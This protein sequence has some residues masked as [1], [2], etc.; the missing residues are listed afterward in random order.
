[1]RAW[2]T[3]VAIVALLATILITQVS[4]EKSDAVEGLAAYDAY[5]DDISSVS[6]DGIQ[7]HDDILTDQYLQSDLN[8][9]IGKEAAGAGD[10]QHSVAVQGYYNTLIGYQAGYDIRKGFYNFALGARSLNDITDGIYNQAIGA[11]SLYS[12]SSGNLNVAIGGAAGY[13]TNGA[14]NVFIGHTSGYTG[15]VTSYSVMIGYQSGYY[16]KSPYRLYIEPSNSNNP[17]IYG[18]F[19]ND[20]VKVNGDLDVV[21]SFGVNDSRAILNGTTGS[22]TFTMPMQGS[23][24]RK[25]LAYCASYTGTVNYV[26]PTPYDFV[27]L[28]MNGVVPTVTLAV[29][30]TSCT[31]TAAV[32][33]TGWFIIDGF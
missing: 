2:I 7:F 10:L 24:E 29:N 4:C 25:V 16:E 8:V 18:E 20:Y 17:L 32:S 33:S 9:I 21:G 11:N 13:A 19:D 23:A 14:S 22:I 31:V 1:M 30:K 15:T 28:Y 6:D 5:F 27:P 12:V 26:F 3:F